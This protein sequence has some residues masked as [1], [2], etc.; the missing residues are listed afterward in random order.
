M[1]C[2]VSSSI[3]L[4]P[5]S[6]DGTCNGPSTV[7]V[8]VSETATATVTE[9]VVLTTHAPVSVAAEQF[10][11]V[12]T[13]PSITVLTEITGTSTIFAT[14]TNFVSVV[15]VTPTSVSANQGPFYFSVHDGTTEWAG[16]K[17]PPATY[18]QVL[19]TATVVVVPVPTSHSTSSMEKALTT[20][21]TLT[22]MS[23]IYL[24]QALTKTVVET[25]SLPLTPLTSIVTIYLTETVVSN[26]IVTPSPLKS[27][28]GIGSSGW[29]TST[30]HQQSTAGATGTGLPGPHTYAIG[31]SG[32]I[33]PSFKSTNSA[34]TAIKS[35]EKI[36][37]MKARQVGALVTA[38][39]NGVIVSWTNTYDGS[40]PTKSLPLA[41]IASTS[42]IVV[43]ASSTTA[44]VTLSTVPDTSSTAPISSSTTMSALAIPFGPPSVRHSIYTNSS[45]SAVVILSTGVVPPIIT[46][47]PTTVCTDKLSTS[48]SATLISSVT[49][50]PTS[51]CNRG[52]G[53]AGNIGNLTINV[54]TRSRAKK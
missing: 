19:Q 51:Q 11:S 53:P 29:N 50:S 47:T 24:T 54:S 3:M 7:F 42:S 27:F 52:Q 15:E 21:S 25:N 12:D 16:G 5:Y 9:T 22:I 37:K 34:P 40:T 33:A 46:S 48:T 2:G 43:P 26:T 13:S 8:T 1:H 49:P 38:T 39:I 20:T 10:Q 41:P 17:T 36:N 32:V 28:T 23:T 18:S 14:H 31:A 45:T 30:T 44:L 6:G 4:T 35:G